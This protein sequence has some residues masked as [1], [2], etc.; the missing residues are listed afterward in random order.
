MAL[1]LK[2]LDEYDEF[3]AE[4]ATRHL[5]AFKSS[6]L[7]DSNAPIGSQ[8]YS[9]EFD[10]RMTTVEAVIR[11]A[12]GNEELDS[13]SLNHARFAIN[14]LFSPGDIVLDL[15]SGPTG[16]HAVWFN[17]TGLVSAIAFDG[18]EAIENITGR[19]ILQTDLRN[20]TESLN[21]IEAVLGHKKSADWIWCHDVLDSVHSDSIDAILQTLGGI[22]TK[23]GIIMTLRDISQGGQVRKDF[24]SSLANTGLG[25][26]KFYAN[27]DMYVLE[28]N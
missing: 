21:V 18:I 10:G 7:I 15:G 1:L 5:S 3:T 2:R 6:L 22:P 11:I 26:A 9:H 19:H 23:K 8:H 20:T 12:L 24:E 4:S 14:E 25:L 28:R 16:A 13:R 17:R 27:M